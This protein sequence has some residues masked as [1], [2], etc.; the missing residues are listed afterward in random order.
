MSKSEVLSYGADILLCVFAIYLFV[1]YFDIFFKRKY[2]IRMLIIGC[3]LFMSW[4][5][6]ITTND[7]FPAYIN[8][9]ISILVTLVSI[10]IAYEGGYANKC[11]FSL[12]FNAIWMLI[13]TLSGYVLSIFCNSTIDPH[14]Y[15]ILGSLISKIIFLLVI[16]ALR[17]VFTNEEIRG[18]SAKY[19]VMFVMIPIGSI[20]IMNDVLY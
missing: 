15:N 7:I 18:L 4:Q 10:I 20:Y 12:A 13:E 2:Q 16:L 6:I 9:S 5:F 19:N 17:K 11:I 8:I 3:T 14:L 1:F